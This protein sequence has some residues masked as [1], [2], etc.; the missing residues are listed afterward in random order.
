QGGIGSE[1]QIIADPT[2][3]M[4]GDYY[5]MITVT[6]SGAA[7]SPQSASIVFRVAAAGT[8][9]G[10]KASPTAAVFLASGT[11]TLSISTDGAGSFATTIA[12]DYAGGAS[13]FKH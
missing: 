9:L 6:G 5:G 4:P 3:L 10:I 7:N 8:S 2:T 1:L 13:F 11:Q 12:D